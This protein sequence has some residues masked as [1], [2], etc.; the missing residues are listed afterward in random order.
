MK[1]KMRG[2]VTGA[3]PGISYFDIVLGDTDDLLLA[4]GAQLTCV[5]SR[6]MLPNV[7]KKPQMTLKGQDQEKHCSTMYVFPLTVLPSL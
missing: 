4:R 6:T 1:K 5:N 2:K 3:S 7:T